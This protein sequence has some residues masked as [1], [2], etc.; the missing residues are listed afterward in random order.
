MQGGTVITL[1]GTYLT[2]TTSV[3][4][5]G[6]PCT[7]V[8]VVNSTSVTAVTPAG[9]V[10]ANTVSVTTPVGTANLTNGFTYTGTGVWY[11]VL[12]QNPNPAIVT[13]ATLRNAIAATGLPWRVR[14]IVTQIEMVLI[15][16]GTF[17]MGCSASQQSECYSFENPVHQVTL[18]NAFYLGRY[19]VTQAQWTARMGSNPS[20]FQSA[21]AEVPQAQ[22]P[23]RPVE[24]VWWTTV[25]GFLSQT[26]M[27][28]PTE[29]E[30]E[31]AY[32]AGTT[33]A[34]HGYTGQLSGTNDDSLLGNIAW[35]W[36]GSCS[37][38]PSCYQTRPVGGKLGNGFGLHDMAGNV[39]EWV[40]D[41]Y[42]DYSA[43]A[44]TNPQ[45]PSSGLWRVMRGG[46]WDDISGSHDC[47]ASTRYGPYGGPP[48]S[49]NYVGIR[50]A[51]TP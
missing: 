29:A 6:A 40:N 46:A 14:D 50:V 10:G 20:E 5:G 18:T 34:F 28:L 45:G 43:D 22:V 44:Q 4:I 25:Q 17:N 21:S 9:T 36:D 1:T 38:G 37:S 49:Q 26:G 7:N 13:S 16:P 47:R 41:W 30:W 39:W 2:D 35:F 11:T 42:G 48:F 33:T 51:R 3:T 12:E 19:E 31:Y 24:R 32:R 15:P 8:Q 23:Q 27:R